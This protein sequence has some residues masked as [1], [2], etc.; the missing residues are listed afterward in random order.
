M[1]G[2]RVCMRSFLCSAPFRSLWLAFTLTVHI[3]ALYN[4][5]VCRQKQDTSGINM[6]P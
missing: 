6:I 5:S 4:E 3:N 1:V 2:V